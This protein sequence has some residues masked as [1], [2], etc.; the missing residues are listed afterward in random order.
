MFLRY[1]IQRLRRAVIEDLA[2]RFASELA[3]LLR[4]VGE[5]EIPRAPIRLVRSR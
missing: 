3:Q 5:T 2:E 1:Q 4:V